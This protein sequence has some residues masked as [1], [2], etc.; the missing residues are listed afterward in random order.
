MM[1]REVEALARA[2]GTPLETA[3][4]IYTAFLERT[5]PLPAEHREPALEVV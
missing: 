3:E 2:T 4:T 5:L 1:P